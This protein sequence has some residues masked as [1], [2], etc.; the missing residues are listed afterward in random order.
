M[1]REKIPHD[2]RLTIKHSVGLGW[3]Q[4]VDILHIV[5]QYFVDVFE[6][7]TKVELTGVCLLKENDIVEQDASLSVCVIKY[8]LIITSI[9]MPYC[10]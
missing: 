5:L 7:L 6:G 4:L 1:P 9:G 2:L 10:Y 3:K 8:Y